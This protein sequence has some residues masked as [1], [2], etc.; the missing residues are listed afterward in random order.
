MFP[1]IQGFRSLC[2]SFLFQELKGVDITGNKGSLHKAIDQSTPSPT[3]MRRSNSSPTLGSSVEGSGS[4]KDSASALWLSSKHTA[5][6]L[7]DKTDNSPKYSLK[8][9]LEMSQVSSKQ[10]SVAKMSSENSLTDSD[11]GGSKSS[12]LGHDK[13]FELPFKRYED[14]KEAASE[15]CSS[16]ISSKEGATNVINI[17]PSFSSNFDNFRGLS[18]SPVTSEA[19]SYVGEMPD[20]TIPRPRRS[21]TIAVAPSELRLQSEGLDV[22][23]IRYKDNMRGGISPSFV[24][25]QLYHGGMLHSGNETPVLLPQNEVRL[26]VLPP[27]PPR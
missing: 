25:L 2:N 16:S 14:S 9:S 11:L 10:K 3:S 26:L 19:S 24:F 5:D 13:D 6:W 23:Q 15:G 27:P 22:H 18:P 8:Q 7:Q 17:N 21:H 1:Q 12:V 20:L 4:V